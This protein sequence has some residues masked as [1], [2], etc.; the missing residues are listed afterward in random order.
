MSTYMVVLAAI[1]DRDRFIT[2][3]GQHAGTL[4]AQYGG[5]YLI[6]TPLVTS[7]EGSLGDGVSAVIS[8]WPNRAAVDEFW[9]SADYVRLKDARKEL[10]DCQVMIL[11]QP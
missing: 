6:R 10:A 2:D 8:K 11:E 9:N 7:L 4:I 5:E 3:Y 1:K